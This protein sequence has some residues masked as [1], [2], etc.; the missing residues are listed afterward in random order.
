[1]PAFRNTPACVV[2]GGTKE[3]AVETAF[4]GVPVTS[5]CPA[6]SAIDSTPV[7]SENASTPPETV[8][9]GV[10]SGSWKAARP[11]PETETPRVTARDAPASATSHGVVN[12]TSRTRAASTSVTAA[13]PVVR[14]SN[15]T[16][17]SGD[18]GAVQFA[19][20]SHAPS[21]TVHA[22]S[23]VVSD[24]LTSTRAVAV[25]FAASTVTVATRPSGTASVTASGGFAPSHV[26]SVKVR[27]VVQRAQE[28]ARRRPAR[29]TGDAN[30][31]VSARSIATA[32]ATSGVAG[33]NARI[34]HVPPLP[35]ARES[36]PFEA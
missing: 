26:A 10:A 1:M 15:H 11:P 20:S 12:A 19:A 25:F 8:A 2:W 7:G 21:A 9:W 22:E 24:R 3:N 5:T 23:G 17:A 33:R 35:S 32:S 16:E 14:S 31:T 13:F 36:R 6:V 29:S 34:V 4:S 27:P 28:K 30:A 18:G